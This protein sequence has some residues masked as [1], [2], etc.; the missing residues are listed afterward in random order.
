M[1][2]RV[3]RG[4]EVNTMTTKVR[5][6]TRLDSDPNHP[7]DTDAIVDDLVCPGG[8]SLSAT[9]LGQLGALVWWRCRACG[10]EHCRSAGPRG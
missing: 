2:A 7:L 8:N 1:L 9:F 10:F 4:D 5:S 6:S 3:H